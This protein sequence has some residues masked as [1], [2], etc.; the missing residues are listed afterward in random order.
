M[1]IERIR[2]FQRRLQ[3]AAAERQV[4]TAHGIG[5]FADSAPRVYDANYLLVDGPP[6]APG[7]LAAEAGASQ[8]HL[9]HRR[10]ILTQSDDAVA[11]G[12]IERGYALSV[13]LVLEHRREPD[14]LVDTSLV[15]EVA[16]DQLVPVR[17]TAVQ[18][19]PW[20]DPEVA[21][22]LNDAKR[23]IIGAV[24]TRFFAAYADGE[25]AAFC[26]LRSDGE[27]AQIEDV[28]T[29]RAHRGRGLGRALVQ[30]A[31]NEALSGHDLVFLEA[32]ADDWPRQLYAKLGFDVV[33]RRDFLTRFPHPATRI[34][35]RTPRLELRLATVSELRRLYE[36]A[37]AGI[38]DPA[39][40]PF[41][42]AWTDA[43]DEESFLAHHA[44]GLAAFR[45]D[46]WALRFVAFSDG[47]PVGVQEIRAERF[48]ERRVVD[49][50]SWLGA[51]WQGQGLGTEMRAAVLSFAFDGLGAERA[52][53]GAIQ[54]N[55][56][57]LAVSRKLGYELVGGHT[58]S[59]R[60]VPVHHD[61]LELT[62]ERFRSPIAV[63]VSG[64]GG[65]LPLFGAGR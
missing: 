39:E 19:E 27:T 61:D 42:V 31:L 49:T 50:G 3:L 10:V 59:P 63:E 21:R 57:S 60:G 34:R 7:V 8:E 17:A 38:H 9:F 16:F 13:H 32:L 15:R 28:E 43:L 62:R 24:D 14:R 56:A 40:M 58:V 37:A 64:L 23:L 6:V 47:R 22:E 33:G 54:G 51:A 25:I 44:D 36:V 1:S 53:S 45:T 20:G 12:L 29:L 52:T 41:G 46:A 48:A 2:A 5:L 55:P 18:A 11:A 26:E 30:H 4:P 65:L 35:L